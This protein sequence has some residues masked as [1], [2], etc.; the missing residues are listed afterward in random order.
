[1]KIAPE[2]VP[3]VEEIQKRF[4]DRLD[5]I[6][7]PRENEVYVHARPGLVPGFTAHLIRQWHGRQVSLF[8]DDARSTEGAFHVYYVFALA[9]AHGFIVL[10]VPVSPDNA[11]FTSLA[12]ALPMVNWQE[13]EIQDLFGLKLI[14]H[15]N[16]RRCAL[17][18]D[19]PEVYP[20]RKISIS[21][22]PA[23]VQVGGWNSG[24]WKAKACSVPV[25]RCTPASSSRDISSSAGRPAGA[26]LQLRMFMRTKAQKLFE[27]MPVARGVRM[28][29]VFR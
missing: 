29:E 19:W 9:A 15:S 5:A 28:A 16:P 18:D 10:R 11:E 24:R 6:Q 3:I 4:H 23:S 22:G 13:R 14:G 17:H 8:A 26:H 25:D 27:N 12:N 2:L 7:S 1:M 21:H 20:L